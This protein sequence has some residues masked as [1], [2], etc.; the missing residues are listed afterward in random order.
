[1]AN[2]GLLGAAH[3]VGQVVAAKK[4]MLSVNI[5]RHF[6]GHAN[7]S[8]FTGPRLASPGS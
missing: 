1:M 7:F 3:E 5:F 6:I 2:R 8:P 4:R